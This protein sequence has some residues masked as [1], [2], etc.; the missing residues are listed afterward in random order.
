MWGVW[1]PPLEDPAH[2]IFAHPKRRKAAGFMRKL[3]G[4]S[5]EQQQ[6]L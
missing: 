5:H 1:V 6:I 2:P 3:S 4:K